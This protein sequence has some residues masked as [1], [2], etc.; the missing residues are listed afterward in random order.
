MVLPQDMIVQDSLILL[1]ASLMG[2]VLKFSLKPNKLDVKLMSQLLYIVITLVI[3]WANDHKET[4]THLDGARREI[5]NL[6]KKISNKIE[7][8]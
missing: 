4:F 2:W 8:G 5:V 1:A 3:K 6:K 7:L